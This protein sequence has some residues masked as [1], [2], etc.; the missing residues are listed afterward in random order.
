MDFLTPP[1]LLL[2]RIAL[3]K[4][5]IIISAPLLTL[6]LIEISLCI[7][8]W[9]TWVPGDSQMNRRCFVPEYVT[10]KFKTSGLN[11]YGYTWQISIQILIPHFVQ[12][13]YIEYLSKHLCIR[14]IKRFSSVLVND[15]VAQP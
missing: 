9:I 8:L 13:F 1:L 15:Q 11:D 14:P 10:R 7:S 6:T 3:T 12:C 2:V 4:L 5:Q